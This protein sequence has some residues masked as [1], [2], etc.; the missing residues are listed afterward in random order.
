ME[1]TGPSVLYDRI[2]PVS[3]DLSKHTV[4]F[5]ACLSGQH[6]GTGLAFDRQPGYIVGSRQPADK[7]QS[8]IWTQGS[9]PRRRVFFRSDSSNLLDSIQ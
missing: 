9:G 7:I 3:H 8:S 2:W 6:Q 4:T 5:S 1:E